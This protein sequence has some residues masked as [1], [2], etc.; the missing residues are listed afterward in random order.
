MGSEKIS[1]MPAVTP[2]DGTEIIPCLQGGVNKRCTVDDILK[3]L[4]VLIGDKNVCIGGNQLPGGTA[5]MTSPQLGHLNLGTL[6]FAGQ[7]NS[8]GNTILLDAATGSAE[9]AGECN[10]DHLIAQDG[11][12]GTGGFTT[13]DVNRGIV[14]NAT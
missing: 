5:D 6:E 14:L 2:L 8:A 13:F 10:A 9:L 12:S 11:F 4:N 1:D 7:V 3:R